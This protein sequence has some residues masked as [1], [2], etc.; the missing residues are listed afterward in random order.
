MNKK[1]LITGA[2]GYLGR[3]LAE[4][5]VSKKKIVT[6]FDQKKNNYL[7]I[8]KTITGNLNNKKKLIK[9][10]KN[11]NTI[12]HFAAI[13]DLQEANKNP[14]RTIENNVD[15]TLKLLQACVLNKVKKFVFAS[16]VYAISEQGGIY[17]T[18]KL[19]A[20]MIVE[21]ICK[22]Y[23]IKFIIL[24]FGTVYGN[25]ANKFNT[26][27]NYVAQALLRKKIFRESKG[28]EVRNYIHVKDAVKLVYKITKSTKYNN[29]YY[30][31]LGNK[32]YLVKELFNIIKKNLPD[33]SIVFSKSDKR[34]YNYKIN[35]FTYKLRIGKQIKLKKYITLEKGLKN[36]IISSGK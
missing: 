29:G 2:S 32:K 33:L 10:T 28:N 14:F 3:N 27:N 17:S 22:K 7:K 26:V 24:R 18:S 4:F 6:L 16:S 9:I 1:Y 5:L 30:N 23:K 36:L 20:E 25:Q 11:T 19:A 31:I 21:R 34:A 13:A 8:P 35:P 15:G 12:F